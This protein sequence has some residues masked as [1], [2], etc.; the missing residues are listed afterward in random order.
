[1]SKHSKA[2]ENKKTELEKIENDLRN[3]LDQESRD[4]ESSIIHALKIAAITGGAILLGYGIYR[5]ST[6][7]GDD[8]EE[9]TQTSKPKKS[10]F[11]DKMV[12]K[13]TDV[14]AG[15]AMQNLS[16]YLDNLKKEKSTKR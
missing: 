4:V 11:F 13:F 8:S 2:Y 5:W 10:D 7:K 16:G 6:K 3:E 14:V 12:D 15:I 9:E 1:M